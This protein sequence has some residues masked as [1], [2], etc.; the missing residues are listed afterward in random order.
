MSGISANT[1]FK[2][3]IVQHLSA[4]KWRLL[5]A[6]LC[7]LGATA[8]Q[9]LAPWPLKL[10]I[11]YVLLEQPLPP[12]L[13]FLESLFERGPGFSLLILSSSIAVIAILN[14]SL[15][16]FQ[17]Y[18]TAKI[19]YQLVHIIRRELFSHLQRLPLSFH[20]QTSIGEILTKFSGDTS[21]L[22]EAFT[23]WAL[24]LVA[25]L[26]TFVGML[27][28]MLS[29][30]WQ[31]ALVVVAT[32][33]TLL[34]VLWY[35]NRQI[36]LSVRT[37]RKQEGQIT[38][39]MNEILS[40]IS[41]VQAFG[42]EE[43]ESDRFDIQ[44]SKNLES[45]IRIVRASA[46][47]TKSVAFVSAIGTAGTV[48]VGSWQVLEGHMTPGDLLIF[49][50]YLRNLYK[51]VRDIGKLWAKFSKASV[52]SDRIAELLNIE[53]AIPEHEEGIAARELNG[54]IT[55][56]QVS[57]GYVS[58]QPVLH[59]VSFKI[60]KG[61]RIAL[62]GASGAGKSTIVNLILRL[63]SPREGSI[64]IDGVN[65]TD[66]QLEFLRSQIGIVLQDTILFGASI[67]ENIAYGKPDATIE[68]V[69]DAARDAH[70]YDFIM[71]F[72]DGFDTVLSERGG[73]LSG[74]QRQRI[75]LARAIIKRPSILIL[76]EPTSAVDP[77][78]SSSIRDTIDHI[79]YGKTTLFI[80]HQLTSMQQYDQILVLKNGHIVEH[81][82]HDHLL[83]LKGH[84]HELVYQQRA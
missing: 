30:N 62:V 34:G 66:Y 75:S 67:I 36:I 48:F 77:I 23:D 73:T 44:S 6:G 9:L 5:L 32:I 49:V 28:I 8:T 59:R 69:E 35:L 27:I 74:G 1:R 10:V 4:N 39:K 16:Y 61:Q 22:R 11:D 58:G 55:F 19:G 45:S 41:L 21:T 53:P 3:L 78:S 51:P 2:T 52:S 14:G 33:P 82:P 24:T 17:M 79:Q 12:T 46:A 57:F 70:A 63:Y 68:E 18:T 81:G 7:L 42:R 50:S 83:E 13:S 84:Y 65:I 47:V 56:D 40:S 76:D 38:S 60:H 31:L 26:L 37:Q 80:S 54:D 15:S 29:L 25:H 71:S 64:Y 43:H 72:P 20:K